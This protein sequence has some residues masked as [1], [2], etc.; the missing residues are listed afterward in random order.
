MVNRRDEQRIDNMVESIKDQIDMNG[1]LMQNIQ[2]TGDAK[3]LMPLVSIMANVIEELWDQ[4][5][6][7]DARLQAVDGVDEGDQS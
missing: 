6:R 4:I 2:R 5:G 7:L 3:G 1:P